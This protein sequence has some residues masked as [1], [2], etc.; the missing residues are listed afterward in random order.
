MSIGFYSVDVKDY[1]GEAANHRFYTTVLTAANW[2]AQATARGDYNVAL[3][4]IILGTVQRQRY[5]IRTKVS[6]A[7]ASD[8]LA[9]RELKMLVQYH[10]DSTGEVM[11][12]LLLPCPDLTNLDP[13]DRSHFN[14]G[15]G[16]VIDAFVTAFE[17]YIIANYSHAVVIDELTLV[18][19]RL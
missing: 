1:D 14:I 4:A 13:A 6:R 9:Q 19:R 18:G 5:G 11:K 17:A 15:D 10:D 16:D 3:S 12:P 7:A 2:A 8:A